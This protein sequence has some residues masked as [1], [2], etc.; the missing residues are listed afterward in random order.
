MEVEK[1]VNWLVKLG[2]G[3]VKANVYVGLGESPLARRME[4]YRIQI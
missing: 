4:L 1:R 3:K 2:E